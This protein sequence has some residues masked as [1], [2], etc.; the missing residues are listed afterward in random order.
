MSDS[1]KN[2]SDIL[3]VS[4]IKISLDASEDDALKIAALEMKR[5][6][7]APARLRFRIYKKSIDARKKVSRYWT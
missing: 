4:G 3:L 2:V 7:I 1:V 5:A 6:G